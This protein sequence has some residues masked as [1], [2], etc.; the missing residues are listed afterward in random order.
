M[1]EI[2]QFKPTARFS[3]PLE[4]QA[5]MERELLLPFSKAQAAAKRAPRIDPDRPA[6]ASVPSKASLPLRGI[7]IVIGG[8]LVYALMIS[9]VVGQPHYSARANLMPAVLVEN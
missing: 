9:H 5:G 4:R 6:T 1:G 2:I 8:V 7:A 3:K